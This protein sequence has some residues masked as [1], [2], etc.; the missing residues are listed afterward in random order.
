MSDDI[1][2]DFGVLGV[3]ENVGAAVGISLIKNFVPEI[4]LLP[5]Y[6]PPF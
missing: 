6:C 4:N 2:N 3:V 1:A 5:V